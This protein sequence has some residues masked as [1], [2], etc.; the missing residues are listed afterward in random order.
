MTTLYCEPKLRDFGLADPGWRGFGG[1][2][3]DLK[4]GEIP[5]YNLEA[6]WKRPIA[7][8]VTG[9]AEP[10]LRVGHVETAPRRPPGNVRADLDARA[11]ININLLAARRSNDQELTFSTVSA[12][13]GRQSINE[14]SSEIQDGVLLT[15]GA[16][17]H[18]F[19]SDNPP[20]ELRY[21]DIIDDRLWVRCKSHLNLFDPSRAQKQCVFR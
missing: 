21:S 12:D 19:A 11:F 4:T 20:L 18:K 13:A 14:Y 3:S 17:Q 8:I 5:Q 6:F 2:I 7:P 10:A 16:S 9:F 1:F 15:E